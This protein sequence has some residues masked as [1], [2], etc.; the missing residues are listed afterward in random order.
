MRVAA[1]ALVLAAAA[2]VQPRSARCKQVCTR[3]SECIS[4]TSSQ[5]PFDEK[6]CIAA[7]AVLEGDQENVAK[8]EHHA[9][10][11]NS[12]TSCAAVLEC[13]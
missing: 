8:V 1:L 2:C 12:Q 7:C 5:I 9:E 11:V 10:C 4:T 13:Q 6:E 3:E